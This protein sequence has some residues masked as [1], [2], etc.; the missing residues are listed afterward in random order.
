MASR[1]LSTGEGN[2][3]VIQG[4]SQLTGG[5]SLGVEGKKGVFTALTR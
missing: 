3:R 5:G 1:V 4:G 2:G